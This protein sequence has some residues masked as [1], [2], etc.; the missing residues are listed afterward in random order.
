[1]SGKYV[2]MQ[3][4]RGDALLPISG[5]ISVNTGYVVEAILSKPD[6][7]LPG[8]YVAMVTEQRSYLDVL[9]VWEKVTRKSAVYVE[10]TDEDFE[11]LWGIYG[12]ELAS[13]LRFSEEYGDWNSFK[14]KEEVVTIDKLGLS[15]KLVGLEETLAGLKAMLV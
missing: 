2:W 14:S 7:S 11:S 6:I 13:Q 1:M 3:P 5:D 12:S 9:N 4:S 10:V 15:G 8:K